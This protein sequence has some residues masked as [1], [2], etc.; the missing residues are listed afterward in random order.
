MRITFLALLVMRMSIR[1]VM[2]IV[3]DYTERR[4]I[5]P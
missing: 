5:C 3:I 4:T 2:R 1:K